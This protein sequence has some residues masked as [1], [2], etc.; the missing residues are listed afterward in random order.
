MWAVE[1]S[2]DEVE[3]FSVDSISPQKGAYASPFEE[4]GYPQPFL[5]VSVRLSG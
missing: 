4:A 5:S 2:V 3:N 1:K